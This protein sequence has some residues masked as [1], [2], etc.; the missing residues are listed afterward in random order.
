MKKNLLLIAGILCFATASFATTHTVSVADF[1]FTPS[2]FTAHPG[3][4]IKW[5]WMNGSHT[6]TSTTIPSGAAPWNSNMNSSTTT[7]TYV[8]TVPGTYNYV[9]TPHASMGMTGTFTV[10]SA[11]NV[12]PVSAAQA[13]SI[14]PNPSSGPLLVKFRHPDMD[15]IVT[16]KDVTGKE[17]LSDRYTG[18][19]AAVLDLGG[20]PN[21]NYIL[22]VQQN[23]AA[24]KREIVLCH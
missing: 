1:S 23:N 12:P 21:G 20:L 5:V 22:I 8:A 3:D 4:T 13:L 18:T 7:F 6:T 16:L 24:D 15:A 17:V 10:V 19:D 11:T 14:Y 9:C 2:S